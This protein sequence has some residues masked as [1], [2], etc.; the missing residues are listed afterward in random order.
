MCD[1]LIISPT[2]T[3]PPDAGNRVRVKALLEFFEET[4]IDYHVAFFRLERGDENAMK[5]RWGIGRCSFFEFKYP[6]RKIPIWKRVINKLYRLLGGYSCIPYLIDDWCDD[7]LLA[8]VRAL[9][10][11][12]DPQCV[13]I[14]YVFLSKLFECLD[15]GVLKILDS[16]DV[17]TDRHKMFL[18]QRLPPEGFYVTAKEEAAG[19]SRADHVLAIQETETA[20]FRQ[21]TRKPVATVGHFVRT[22]RPN[23]PITSIPTLMF[24]GSLN[25]PNR[26]AIRYFLK[27]IWPR[28]QATVPM[29]VVEVYGCISG[30][31]TPNL[32]GVKTMGPVEH[33]SEG[34]E[35]AW[36]VVAP[37]RFGTGLKIKS[38]EALGLGKALVSSPAAYAG[39]EDGLGKAFLSG[40]SADEF[41]SACI[42][43]LLDGALRRRL[44]CSAY[45]YAYAWNVR[46]RETLS[47][48][49]LRGGLGSEKLACIDGDINE[50]AFTSNALG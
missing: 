9:V 28:V 22:K 16:H 41:A 17:F 2:P 19:I 50:A 14:E 43:L 45:E 46:Q 21:L 13:Q 24:L 38:I 23:N 10:E 48:I 12:L 26:D 36:V 27:E 37:L 34:Y 42:A 31:V 1:L 6:L 3:H 18:R 33:P 5:E 47:S 39:L 35:R 7:S 15:S 8:N 25:A 4:G 49:L 44:E 40:A 30:Y 11:S 32:S 29:A 20:F